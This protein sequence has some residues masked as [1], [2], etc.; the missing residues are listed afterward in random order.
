MEANRQRYRKSCK[1]TNR[2]INNLHR[3]YYADQIN[4]LS[5][6]PRKRWATVMELL[7]T[8]DKD[9]TRTEED[10]HTVCAAIANFFRWQDLKNTE[11]TKFEAGW[12][13][14][15]SILVWCVLFG[16]QTDVVINC[17]NNWGIQA[18]IWYD[19]EIFTCWLD[20]HICYKS[21]SGSDF[22]ARRT[23][24]KLSFTEGCFPDRFKWA[25]VTPLLKRVGVDKNIP[26][27]Y[28][29]ISNLNTISKIME[30]LASVRLRQYLFGSSSFNRPLEVIT[31][32][33]WRYFGQLLSLNEATMLIALDISA[34]FNMV[35]HSTLRHRLTYSFGI[36][37]V[38]LRWIESFLSEHSVR[39]NRHSFFE[40][41]SVWLWS[42][43]RT[44]PWTNPFHRL[45]IAGGK[46][47][48]SIQSCTAPICRRH[49]IIHCY[50]KDIISECYH[51]TSKLCE[52]N[53]LQLCL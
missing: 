7:H 17:H 21:V 22:E 41:D 45:Y 12:H 13:G 19:S 42:S 23:S 4:N 47:C 34:L 9:K 15:W 10:N 38:A 5:Q 49:A 3:Q 51:T 18:H 53:S 2:L 33:K 30:G 35:V 37:D 24:R 8:A 31:R 36:D 46:S 11:C 27:N 26:V 6:D 1:E 32:H 29:R 52:F 48:R 44:G 40:T 20:F 25:Q 43:S 16:P 28:W 39:S 50:V 14:I